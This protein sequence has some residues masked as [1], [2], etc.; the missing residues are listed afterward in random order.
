MVDYF[1]LSYLN[2]L[3]D[4][5]ATI[6]YNYAWKQFQLRFGDARDFYSSLSKDIMIKLIQNNVLVCRDMS[7][8]E[9]LMQ[10]A[11]NTFSLDIYKW[12]IFKIDK[13]E[14]VLFKQRILFQPI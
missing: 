4:S 9:F 1:L 2:I 14:C 3:Q 12:P 7:N 10:M 13:W 6:I 11:L 8:D 5:P